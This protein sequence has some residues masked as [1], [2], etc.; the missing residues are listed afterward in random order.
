MNYLRQADKQTSNPENQ[1]A[2]YI[3]RW[4]PLHEG[5]KFI[6][7]ESLE[8]G[9]KVCIAIRDIQPDEKNPFSPE[10]VKEMIEKEYAYLISE[11]KVK[12]II[13]PDICSVNFGRGVGYDII[14][15]EV[16]KHIA[17][18]SATAI[19]EKMKEQGVL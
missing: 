13:L 17:D 3:G 9:I 4:Q 1:Y 5:H 15:H 16:P 8:K 14:E 12:V 10:Q 2:L 18:I 7:N 11:G 6:F 19:R